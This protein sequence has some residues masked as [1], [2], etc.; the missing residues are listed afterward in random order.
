[1]ELSELTSL[2]FAA[3]DTPPPFAIGTANQTTF[4]ITNRSQCEIV[5]LQYDTADVDHLKLQLSICPAPSDR[6]TAITDTPLV[7]PT[8]DPQ[9]RQPPHLLLDAVLLPQIVPPSIETVYTAQ[10]MCAADD[11]SATRPPLLAGLTNFGA[12]HVQTLGPCDRLWT[13]RWAD[14]SAM[15]LQHCRSSAGDLL[16]AAAVTGARVTSD[17]LVASVRTV[18]LVAFAWQSGRRRQRRHLTAPPPPGAS[19]HRLVA[20]SA[21]GRAV[22]FGIAAVEGT[23]EQNARLVFN[24]P[25]KTADGCQ[26]HSQVT[27]AV[28]K[29]A[30]DHSGAPSHLCTADTMGNIRLYAVDE[31]A[32]TG[33]T[34]G[35][36]HLVDCVQSN[37]RCS[38]GALHVSR[39][40]AAAADRELM[41]VACLANK[42]LACHVDLGASAAGAAAVTLCVHHVRGHCITGCARIA[43][44]LYAICTHSG[45]VQLLQLDAARPAA[46]VRRTIAVRTPINT[47][48]YQLAG[49][50]VS[51]QQALWLFVLFPRQPFDHLVLRQP[52]SVSVCTP[53]VDALLG[54][55]AAAAATGDGGDVGGQWRISDVHDC[56]EVLRY[57][58]LRHSSELEFDMP[59]LPEWRAAAAA[60]DD[61][62]LKHALRVRLL[63]LYCLTGFNL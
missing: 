32:R 41:V 38:I 44:D 37:F 35:V 15:W 43:A 3:A 29:A 26:Q 31:D 52:L 2:T 54:R 42:V 33:D 10:Q 28:W 4:T 61:A 12:L 62:Q 55:L 23:L 57:R 53:P 40:A 18:Q 17:D 21:A 50:A 47:E 16:P 30:S 7:R 63:A 20:I 45:L 34:T 56:A 60:E 13:H 51:R 14:L 58:Q 25:L 19:E 24:C 49:L 5:Q 8:A 6:A 59:A 36:R 46:L 11:T 22:F 1:M 48:R 27:H 9:Q 39:T